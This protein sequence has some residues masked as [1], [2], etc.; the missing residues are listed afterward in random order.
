MVV[1]NPQLKFGTPQT[2]YED[3]KVAAKANVKKPPTGGTKVS[4]IVAFR[5]NCTVYQAPKNKKI[6]ELD[7]IVKNG[8]WEI[9]ERPA[10][11]N[12]MSHKWVFKVKYDQNQDVGNLRH[13]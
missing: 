13:G 12:V 7:E 3:E 10:V 6:F 8:T 11:G 2:R 4:H 1:I 9:V 5:S